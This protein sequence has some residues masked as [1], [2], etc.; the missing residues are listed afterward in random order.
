[1]SEWVFF[2]YFMLLIPGMREVPDLL[3]K[4]LPVHGLRMKS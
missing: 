1:M 4:P 3:E 2:K